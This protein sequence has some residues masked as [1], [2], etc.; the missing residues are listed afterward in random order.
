M[1][2]IRLVLACVLVTGA[3]VASAGADEVVPV[4]K[5]ATWSARVGR[6]V[7][8][9]LSAEAA[10]S[11]APQ[12]VRVIV[13]SR[14]AQELIEPQ[15]A[16]GSGPRTWRFSPRHEGTCIIATRLEPSSSTAGE[17]TF[18]YEKLFLRVAPENPEVRSTLR[19]S[20]SAT[21]RFG[22]RL[23]LAP[24]VDP[25]CLLVGADL[26]VRVKFDGLNLKG[27]TVVARCEPGPGVPGGG[28]TPEVKAFSSDD[29]EPEAPPAA[30][31]LRTNESASVNIPIRS[32]GLWT[33]SVEHRPAGERPDAN[34][35]ARFVA[36]M[37][38]VVSEADPE[39]ADQKRPGQQPGDKVGEFPA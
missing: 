26:P 8:V 22:H 34:D 27:A 6:P 21:A 31:L 36:T 17:R 12:D 2:N 4:V 30:L 23:E 33:I 9:M 29:P 11:I 1:K 39:K 18:R 16:R 24:L 7:E 10:R 15:P 32:A 35:A 28:D 14:G 19:P 37:T 13:R 5:P 20:A 3:Y 38:F 25:A